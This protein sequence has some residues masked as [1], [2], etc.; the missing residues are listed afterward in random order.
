M[1][2]FGNCVFSFLVVSRK[3]NLN[4]YFNFLGKMDSGLA[5]LAWRRL[6]WLPLESVVWQWLLEAHTG[7][8]TTRAPKLRKITTEVIIL[9][10][11]GVDGKNLAH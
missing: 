2:L 5:E 6:C 8:S 9:L 3:N 11:F 1:K 7:Q 4:L 10:I